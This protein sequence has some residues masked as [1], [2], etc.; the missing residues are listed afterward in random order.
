MANIWY[1]LL[2]AIYTYAYES[3][4]CV[5]TKWIFERDTVN[6]GTIH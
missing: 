2:P 1:G 4:V 6:W 5:F 3:R